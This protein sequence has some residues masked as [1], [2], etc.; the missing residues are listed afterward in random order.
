MPRS[1]G[2]RG[3]DALVRICRT[4]ASTPA[5]A[6]LPEPTLNIS[7]DVATFER[8]LATMGMIDPVAPD[9]TQLPLHQW[10]CE[11]REGVLVDPVQAV[12]AAM[13]GHIRRVVSGAAGEVVDL[14]RRRRW[15]TGAVRQ[16]VQLT[17]SRCVWPGCSVIV[18]RCQI[19]HTVDW[20]HLGSTNT[21]NGAVLC[22]KHNRDKNHGHRVRRDHTGRWHTYRPDGTEIAPTGERSPPTI[23]AG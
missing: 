1:D 2:Q 21:G 3:W 9:V 23:R 13:A 19:D 7:M 4:A 8:T 10:R 6:H 12:T 17:A 16:A 14:G 5:D 22:G 15:F 18:G 11:P 20:H